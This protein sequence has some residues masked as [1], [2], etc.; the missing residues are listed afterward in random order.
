[1]ISGKISWVTGLSKWNTEWL[2]ILV[3]R[4]LKNQRAKFTEVGTSGS[5][6]GVGEQD[7]KEE[8]LLSG[9]EAHS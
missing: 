9:R 6:T 3:M 1:M 4:D 5:S 2:G 8:V 7:W